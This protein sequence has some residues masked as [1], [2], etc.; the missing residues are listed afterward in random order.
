MQAGDRV[1]IFDSPGH[2]LDH[3]LYAKVIGEPTPNG[4]LVLVEHPGNISDGKMRW[5]TPAQTR[6]AADALKLAADARTQAA[7]TMDSITRV[8]LFRHAE[9]HSFIATQLS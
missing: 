6:T 9:H 4:A 1:M 5:A 7:A 2:P 8:M 3:W